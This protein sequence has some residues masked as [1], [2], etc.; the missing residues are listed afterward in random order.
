WA[1]YR[2]NAPLLISIGAAAIVG[3]AG[4]QFW[5]ARQAERA[6]AAA[7][8]FSTAAE[9]LARSPQDGLVAMETLSEEAP[10]GYAVLAALRRAG[11]LVSTGDREGAL[12]IYREVYEDGAAP[13]RLAELARVKAAILSL[14]DGRDAVLA[15]LGALPESASAFAPYARELVALAAFSAKDYETAHAM[16]ER[17]ANDPETPEAVRQRAEEFAALA[18]AG[19]S[20]VR[21]T[22]EASV[23]DLQRALGADETANEAEN[24]PAANEA[25]AESK[26][27]E[28][29]GESDQGQ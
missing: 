13:K 22:G 23:E 15:D 17:A 14:S 11:A 21:L 4:W 18:A 19:R 25:A 24:E 2:K 1:L 27:P 6:A 26:A 28:A 16:F 3:V 29:G 7:L 20:G 9:T 10:E 8:E 5:N 12:A